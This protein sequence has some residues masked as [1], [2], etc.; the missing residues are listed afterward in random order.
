MFGWKIILK[1][2]GWKNFW[3]DSRLPLILSLFI[4]VTTYVH[5]ADI[6]IQL[7]NIIKG[8]LRCLRKRVKK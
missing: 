3:K 7:K 6:L 5:D 4:S 2:Y 1:N 8:D